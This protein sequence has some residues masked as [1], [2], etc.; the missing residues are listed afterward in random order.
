MFAIQIYY[1]QGPQEQSLTMLLSVN[2][3][4]VSSLERILVV[5]VVSI[6]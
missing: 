6:L 5:Y 1:V 4:Y 3:I 2:I